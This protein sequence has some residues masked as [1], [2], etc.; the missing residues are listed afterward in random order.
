MRCLL[1]LAVLF[2]AACVTSGKRG[3]EGAP[4]L[5]DL[6]QVRV[7]EAGRALPLSL[8]V[9]TAPGLD[10]E[11]IA[12]RLDY[13]NPARRNE[14][15]RSRW[16]APPAALVRQRLAADVG[17]TIV[18]AAS[19]PC[20]LRL[21]LDEFAQVFE[22]P[23]ESRGEIRA[24]GLLLDRQRRVVAE[25]AWRIERPAPSANAAGGVASP[26]AATEALAGEIVAW[27]Q[28]LAGSGRLKACKP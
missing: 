17:A 2:L 10:S 27:Q 14:Y 6:G 5:Y 26:G 23:R 11:G 19:N 12:Y 28:N 25:A 18:G 3:S 20:L 16:V 15:S 22:S 24:R 9:R 1:V 4:V 8:E 21:E 13:A 7:A